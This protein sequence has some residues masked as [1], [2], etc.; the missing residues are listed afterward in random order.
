M[1]EKLALKLYKLGLTAVNRKKYDKALKLFDDALYVYPEY[2][3]ALNRKALLL[4]D[5]GRLEEGYQIFTESN[6]IGL[7]KTGDI[8]SDINSIEA[9]INSAKE[10]RELGNGNRALGFS[11]QAA[12]L[13]P[14]IDKEGGIFMHHTNPE[15]YY[16][17]AL[18]TFN[19]LKKYR[20]A[21]DYFN[22]ALKYDSSITIP[23]E[24]KAIYN[25]FAA[26]RSGEGVKMIA[27]LNLSNLRD[28][29]PPNDK[30]LASTKASC[31]GAY[32]KLSENKTHYLSW[33]S[34]LLICDNGIAFQGVKPLCGLPA[35][36]IPWGG[37]NYME[38]RGN[39][40]SD[41]ISI[42]TQAIYTI[43]GS[44]RVSPLPDPQTKS[45]DY[46]HDLNLRAIWEEKQEELLRRT[47]VNLKSF[48]SIPKW[49]V[50]MSQIEYIDK[51][52]YKEIVKVLKKG[53]G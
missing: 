1:D 2:V 33:E 23:E 48:K 18:V 15:I 25:E 53:R 47:A 46:F 20:Q 13:S 22:K 11:M 8:P 12:V 16:E 14:I 41:D 39:I 38:R 35:Y 26:N 34:H 43:I 19:F 9:W 31:G 7:K 50:Y 40:V 21:M 6:L 32:S 24:I 51:K 17:M 37:V 36:Y 28:I 30:I 52:K 10:L 44:L 27:P 29:I 49:K 5:L 42:E 4:I 45:F 3:D